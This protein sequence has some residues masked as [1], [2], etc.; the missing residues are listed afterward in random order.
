[1]GHGRSFIPS[2]KFAAAEDGI[3]RIVWMPRELKEAVGERLN[4]TAR[5]LYG[6]EDFTSLIAD[7]RVSTV[8]GLLEFL[9]EVRHP[10]L[11]MEP[12]L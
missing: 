8:E 7:E 5:E 1:M 11:D 6:I 12:L 9:K 3:R 2:N 4:A 10:V